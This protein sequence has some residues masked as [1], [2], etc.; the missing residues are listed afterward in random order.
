MNINTAGL[1]GT[2]DLH[3]RGL[4]W[5]IADYATASVNLGFATYTGTPVVTGEPG[6]RHLRILVSASGGGLSVMRVSAL[7][8][9]TASIRFSFQY[10][11]NY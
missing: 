11:T 5:P 7:T 9:G 2:N 8:S 1:T 3:I 10:N 6:E 4:P